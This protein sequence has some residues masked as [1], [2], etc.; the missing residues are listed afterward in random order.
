MARRLGYRA[1]KAFAQLVDGWPVSNSGAG[2]WS[3]GDVTFTTKMGVARVDVK[4]T[5]KEKFAFNVSLLDKLHKRCTV[6]EFPVIAVCFCKEGNINPSDIYM[7]VNHVDFK[8]TKNYYDTIPIDTTRYIIRKNVMT[9]TEK[10]TKGQ[11]ILPALNTSFTITSF[12][13]F[14][15]IMT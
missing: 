4:S 11:V 9:R 14:I 8:D 15:A 12:S 13:H 2:K 10:W 5:D 6:D 3:K 1:E 7:I